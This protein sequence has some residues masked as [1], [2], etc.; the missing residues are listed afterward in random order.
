MNL[1][2]KAYTL[3]FLGGIVFSITA[4][5]GED[6]SVWTDH[7]GDIDSNET[8]FENILDGSASLGVIESYLWE[9]VSGPE[10]V[11]IINSTSPVASFASSVEY[12]GSD[13][14]FVFKLT[15]SS[16]SGSDEDLVDVIVK[17]EQ[18]DPPVVAFQGLDNFEDNSINCL[19]LI[20]I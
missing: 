7:N 20:H 12:G 1:L 8:V 9:Q 6:S 17:P 19:S 18:N 5:A 13:K 16:T 15:V 2:H 3:F 4:D 10:E 11:T 14:E